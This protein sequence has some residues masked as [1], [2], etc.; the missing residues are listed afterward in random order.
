MK[1][2]LATVVLCAGLS[3]CI[4]R[5]VVSV[6]PARCA[7][8]IPASW[9]EGVDA[10]PVPDTSGMSAIDQIKAWATAYVGMGG[11]LEKANGRTADTVAIIARCETLMNEARAD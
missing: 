5:P 6:P 1:R 11:Q 8:L 10:E 3:G 7:S 9:A 2:L 4:S